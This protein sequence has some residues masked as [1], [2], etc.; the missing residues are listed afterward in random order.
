MSRRW[1]RDQN[2]Y[3]LCTPSEVCRLSKYEQLHIFPMPPAMTATL[4]KA[5]YFSGAKNDRGDTVCRKLVN[6]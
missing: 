5:F 6:L 1:P 3:V 2:S 4:R